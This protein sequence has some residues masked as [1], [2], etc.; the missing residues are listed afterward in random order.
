MLGCS[1]TPPSISLKI[2]KNLGA[3]F[4]GLDQAYLTP[5]KLNAQPKKKKAV[6]NKQDQSTSSASSSSIANAPQPKKHKKDARKNQDKPTSDG[7][8][9]NAPGPGPR[10]LGPFNLLFCY[11]LWLLELGKF[12]VGM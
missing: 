12:Y 2:N 10:S 1:A 4:C 7:S 8:R 3:S 11:L 5:E 6:G 9:K